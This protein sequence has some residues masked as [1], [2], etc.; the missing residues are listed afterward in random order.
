MKGRSA[1]FRRVV[2]SE[3]LMESGNASAPADSTRQV[4]NRRESLREVARP[5]ARIMSSGEDAPILLV[6]V[7]DTAGAPHHAGQRVL[8]HVD[9]QAGFL[10]E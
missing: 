4:T 1:V 7:E 2:P 8:V 3:R 5:G 9:G 6:I 10:L